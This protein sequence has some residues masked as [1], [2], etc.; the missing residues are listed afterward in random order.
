MVD[1][2]GGLTVVETGVSCTA[3]TRFQICSV[4]KQF[5]AAAVMLLVESGRVDLNEPL[6]RW[7]PEAPP[8]WR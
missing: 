6:D 3:G 5:T 8:Q 7:M 4:S 1:L 2:A